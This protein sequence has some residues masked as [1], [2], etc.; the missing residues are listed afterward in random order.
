MDYDIIGDVHGH[1]DE[2]EVLLQKLGYQLQSGIYH[3]PKGRQAVFLGDFID[4]GT[5]IRETLH[6][7]KNMCDQGNAFAIMG[8][9]EFNAVCFHTP[10]KGKGGFFREHGFKEIKQHYATLEQFSKFPDEWNMFL[11]WFR[12]L[13]LYLNFNNFRVVHACWDD[14]H[15]DWLKKNNYNDNGLTTDFLSRATTKNTEEYHLIEDMLKGIEVELP[16]GVLFNDKDGNHRTKCRLKWWQPE[17]K[18]ETNKDALLF[19]PTRIEDQPYTKNG[20]V[21]NSDKP[22]FFGH[23]WFKVDPTIENQKCICLDYSV[24]KGGKL[25]AF[26]SEY[27]KSNNPE[28]GIVY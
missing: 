3:P 11:D 2:L 18:R 7:V 17:N 1:A 6:I 28:D 5:K 4:R 13:P 26:K 22:V 10:K 16:P 15:I 20:Y 27:L 23:Y 12:H 9:H 25:V 24:A 14:M 21:Y 8:N 19:C